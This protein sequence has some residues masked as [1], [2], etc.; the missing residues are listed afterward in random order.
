MAT[1]T[2]HERVPASQVDLV[3]V[4]SKV[5]VDHV[6]L[7][8]SPAPPVADDFMYDFKFNHPLP[9][10]QSLGINIPAG[11]DAQQTAEG[12]VSQLSKA[13]IAGDASAFGDLFFEFGESI[14][15]KIC[16]TSR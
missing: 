9:T 11:C 6:E 2:Y 7:E 14:Y 13:M 5:L 3:D 1:V 4:K 8:A 15:L 12:I 16:E 10:P